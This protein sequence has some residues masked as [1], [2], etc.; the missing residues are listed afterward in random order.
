MAAVVKGGYVCD[1]SA[2]VT[3]RGCRMLCVC[4]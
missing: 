3:L 4:A 1:V 2:D